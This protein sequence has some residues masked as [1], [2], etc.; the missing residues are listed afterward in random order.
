MNFLTFPAIASEIRFSLVRIESSA[1]METTACSRSPP[2]GKKPH[3]SARQISF[4]WKKTN[5][6]EQCRPRIW[7]SPPCS[8]FTRTTTS[9]T[10]RPTSCKGCTVSNTLTPLVTKSSTIFQPICK[11]Q[12]RVNIGTTATRKA[13]YQTRLSS[14]INTF[15][16]FFRSIFLGLWCLKHSTRS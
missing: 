8:L 3:P 11:K 1:E 6:K 5:S 7:A 4:L 9:F 14:F 12:K 2:A 15:N 16:L 10:F 13:S